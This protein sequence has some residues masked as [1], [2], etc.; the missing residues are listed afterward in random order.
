[1]LHTNDPVL[2]A[3]IQKQLD[4]IS[5]QMGRVMSRTARS[6]IFSDSHDFSCFIADAEGQLVSVAD[7]IPIHTGGGGFAIRAV[8][9]DFGTS[10]APDDLFILSDPYEAGGNHLP[11]WTLVRPVFD[12]GVLIAFTCNRA[13]QSDIGGGAAGT[14]N[15]EA[16]E[17][18]HEGIRLPVVKL[19]DKGAIR[20]DLWKLLLINSRCPDLLDGDLRAMIGSTKVGHDRVLAIADEHGTE[21]TLGCF[22][23][24]IDHA[25]KRMRGALSR[26]PD[27]E[28]FGEDATDT[29]CFDAV[30]VTV[31]AR[32]KVEGDQLLVDF[33]G[34][35]PQIKG[36]KNSSIA[37][38][39]SA[40][41]MGLLS[42]LDT[43][44]PRNEGAFKPITIVAPEGTIVNAKPPAPMTMNTVNPATEIVYAIWKAL[45]QALP[46][47]ACAGWGKITNCISS[48]RLSSDEDNFVM[49]HWHAFP[50]GGA[51]KGRDGFG[52]IGNLVTL[53]G[54]HLPN[55]ESY[56]Q[57]YPITIHQQEYRCDAAG[58]GQYRGGAGIRYSAD[59]HVEA[60]Y[61]FRGEGGR[62]P[63]GYGVNGGLTGSRGVMR[64]QFSGQPEEIEAPQYGV[65]R[66]KPLKVL[67][68][69]PGGGGWGNP[70]DRRPDLV[71][72]DVLDGLV[73]V[74]AASDLYGVHI[75]TERMEVDAEQTASLRNEATD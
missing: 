65:R 20:T 9:D 57:K 11:D 66:L 39:Y 74:Q 70:F 52:T 61:S 72:A 44:I 28:Y 29:D 33:T 5:A 17:I 26:I 49:Y 34:T 53:G 62:T 3:L 37:N 47:E 32:L 38:T 64:L 23:G 73:S 56:E 54:M 59:V 22:R 42:F 1:M 50:A 48:G 71:L 43:T 67:I 24:I 27:G 30:N 68:D 10:I 63:S 31:R 6:P 4:H 7:G 55:V 25:H 35:D 51:V 18:Y 2:L 12:G 19:A 8:L 36:F 13:H 75:D 58:A 45:G 60:E 41:Y 40:V 21:K 69:S 15:S 14:Y 16:T 46:D